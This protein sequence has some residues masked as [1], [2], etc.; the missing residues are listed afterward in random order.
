M[1]NVCLVLGGNLGVLQTGAG[2]MRA[3]KREDVLA[4]AIGIGMGEI[5]WCPS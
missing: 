1:V 3:R 5:A 4:A 2:A